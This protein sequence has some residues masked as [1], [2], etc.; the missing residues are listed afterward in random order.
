MF[1]VELLLTS[2]RKLDLFPSG[3]N[4]IQE[5]Q[6]DSESTSE[7][8]CAAGKTLSSVLLLPLNSPEGCMSDGD[9]LSRL[10]TYILHH[11][12]SKPLHCRGDGDPIMFADDGG[13]PSVR[14]EKCG[15]CSVQ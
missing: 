10:Q 9:K 2:Y 5:H 3:W 13:L 15:L 14:E 11:L 4:P 8:E 1:L 12:L 6:I 7:I